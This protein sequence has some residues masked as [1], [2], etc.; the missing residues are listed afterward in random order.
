M[1]WIKYVIYKHMHGEHYY[2][3]DSDTIDT[4]THDSMKSKMFDDPAAARQHIIDKG[5]SSDWEVI[6]YYESDRK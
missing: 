6:P 4:W 5:F 2:V 3:L 1:K